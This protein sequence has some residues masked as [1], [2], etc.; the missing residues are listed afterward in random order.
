M[1]W[2][3]ND[4]RKLPLRGCQPFYRLPVVAFL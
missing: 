1:N 2:P 4:L 3:E